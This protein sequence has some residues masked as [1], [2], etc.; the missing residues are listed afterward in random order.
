MQEQAATT[1]RVP[2]TFWADHEYRQ[3]GIDVCTVVKHG[4]RITTIEGT[5]EQVA[6]L[7]SDAEYYADPVSAREL[8]ADG[9]GHLINSAQRT[10]EALKKQG[11]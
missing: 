6:N 2:T 10:I 3:D 7:L 5:P 1:Y 4:K 9:Y 8:R 11:N